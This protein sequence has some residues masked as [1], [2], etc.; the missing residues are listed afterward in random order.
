MDQ[1]S[2]LAQLHLH[3]VLPALVELARDDAVAKEIATRAFAVELHAGDG[4]HNLVA[5]ENGLVRISPDSVPTR[6]VRLRFS[7]AAALN[8]LFLGRAA[9]PPLPTR[10]FWRIGALRRFISL[11]NRLNAVLQPREPIAERALLRLHARLSFGVALRALPLVAEHDVAARRIRAATPPGVFSLQVPEAGFRAWARWD[12]SAVTS[13]FG[14][15]PAAVTAAVTVH[16]FDTALAMLAGSADSQAAVGL[17]RVRV[18]GLLLLADGVDALLQ[19]VDAYLGP[20]AR[21]R[22]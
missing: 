11:T 16:D 19:R 9:L 1:A 6:A 4:L 8:A 17:G 13:G 3:A 18:E 2:L 15:P 14:E 21:A 12:G 20:A 5:A 22:S 7:S 10:G